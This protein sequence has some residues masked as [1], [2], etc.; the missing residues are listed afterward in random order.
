[1]LHNR[2]SLRE[3]VWPCH[4]SLVH[5]L[6][7]CLLSMTRDPSRPL[8]SGASCSQLA[9][10]T[11]GSGGGV[12]ADGSSFLHSLEAKGQLLSGWADVEV[13]LGVVAKVC[14]D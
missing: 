11:G 14:N 9:T 12:V 8:V 1:V 5:R 7:H 10:P 4:H 13:V 3:D 2:F 6:Q